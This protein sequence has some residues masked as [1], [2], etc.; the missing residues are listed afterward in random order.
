[1]KNH[2]TLK[3]ILNRRC[4]GIEQEE[5][6]GPQVIHL[7]CAPKETPQ[8][9]TAG[10]R[11]RQ[12]ATTSPTNNTNNAGEQQPNSYMNFAN[13]QQGNYFTGMP[14]NVLPQNI[15]P[16]QLAYYANW[17]GYQQAL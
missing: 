3:E 2:Q 6:R 13:I 10:V 14:S 8:M 5:E 12:N 15:T 7:V 11:R 16:E 17:M 4:E 9:A 1:M